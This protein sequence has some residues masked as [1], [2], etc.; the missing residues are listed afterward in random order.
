M[1]NPEGYFLSNRVAP[2]Y[3]KKKKNL[4]KD[5]HITD[6]IAPAQNCLTQLDQA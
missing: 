1:A 3:L 4:K 2:T 6:L 5:S